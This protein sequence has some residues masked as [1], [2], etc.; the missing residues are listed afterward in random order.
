MRLPARS[1]QLAASATS[2]SPLEVLEVVQLVVSMPTPSSLQFQ[3]TV[4]GVL[5]QPAAFGLD[6]GVGAA[7]GA[8]VSMASTAPMSQRSNCGR[9]TPR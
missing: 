2:P 9:V 8:V 6:E 1:A 7:T 4:T 3:V 5:R